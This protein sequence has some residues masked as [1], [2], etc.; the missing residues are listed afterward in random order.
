MK[1]RLSVNDRLKDLRTNKHM[2]LEDLS[3]ETGIPK[4]SLG[5][6]EQENYPVPHPI[7]LQLADYYGVSTDY[8]LG[9]TD[10]PA[11]AMTP[12]SALH[13]SD[14]AIEKLLKDETNS[15]LISEIIESEHFQ[16][17]LI[18]AEIYIDG[19]VEQSIDDY[20]TLMRFARQKVSGQTTSSTDVTSETLNH[21]KVAQQEYFSQLFSNE[22]IQILDEIKEKHRKDSDTSDGAY[23]SE[24]YEQIF[25]AI[26]DHRSG[27][28][29]GLGAGILEALR[30]KKS[31]KN[32]QDMDRLI[33]EDQPEEAAVTDLLGQS[34][35]IE[36]DARKRRKR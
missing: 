28:L 5:N 6:Y 9:I 26:M 25:Q 8:L 29:N 32:L 10:S 16:Q 7:I 13:L 31:E 33:E 15:R 34:P 23:T 35:I 22:L 18:D 12:V 36:P 20:N 19:Y 4:A 1:Y 17:F 30:I 21:A 24:Q 3:N 2:H 11:T 14:A 27:P